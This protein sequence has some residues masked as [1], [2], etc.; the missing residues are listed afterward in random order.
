MYFRRFRNSLPCLDPNTLCPALWYGLLYRFGF[1][2]IDVLAAGRRTYFRGTRNSFPKNTR[3][4]KLMTTKF[5]EV[6]TK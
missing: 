5:S 3:L 6:E 1:R 4:Y 2:P